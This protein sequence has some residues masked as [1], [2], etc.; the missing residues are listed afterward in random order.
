[1]NREPAPRIDQ[2]T[3]LHKTRRIHL[4]LIIMLFATITWLLRAPVEMV[5]GANRLDKMGELQIEPSPTPQVSQPN[6]PRGTS[7]IVGIL[8]LL[9]PMVFLARKSWK[10]KQ[11]KITASCCLPVIDG[12]HNPLQ[13][14]ETPQAPKTPA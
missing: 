11:P 14:K 1:M 2:H 8:I 7:P 13:T 6:S 3:G 9:A 5:S 12:D 4:I 10:A